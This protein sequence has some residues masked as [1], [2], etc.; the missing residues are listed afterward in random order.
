MIK[1]GSNNRTT[2]CGARLALAR[3]CLFALCLIWKACGFAVAQIPST[4]Q[5]KPPTV[6]I[7]T[8]Q[9]IRS[10][11]HILQKQGSVSF[12]DTPI[13]EVIYTLS[14]QWGVNIIAGS[15]VSGSVSGSFKDAP[16][17]EIL[18]SL[19]SVSGYGYRQNG[20]SLLVLR[21]DQIGP[22]NPNFRAETLLLPRDTSP[23]GMQDIVAALRVFSTKSGGQLQGIPANNTILAFDSPDKIEQMRQI[24]QRLTGM[25]S[26][27]NGQL[28][29]SGAL[30]MDAN[31]G[32]GFRTQ[33][34]D[35]VTLR[36][37]YISV[38]ELAKGVQLAIGNQGTFIPIE[39][40][41]AL[42]VIGQ[43]D[44]IRRVQQVLRQLDRPRAQVR[45]TAY[46]YDISLGEEEQSGVDWSSRIMGAGLD[47]NGIPRDVARSDSG[48]LTRVQPT[49]IVGNAVPLGSTTTTAATG[50]AAAAGGP[51]WVF[52]SLSNNFELNTAI[53]ALDETKGAKLLADPHVT[54]IDRQQASIN[55]ITKIPIQQLT[56]TQQGG[57]IGTTAFEE[58]GIKL[59]VTPRIASDRTIQMIVTPEVSTLTGYNNGNPIIDARRATTTVRVGNQHTL[60]IGGLRQKSAVETIRGVPGLM[61][62]KYLGRLFRSHNTTMKESEL[63]V[64][65]QPEIVDD[66]V[67]GLPRE[68]IALDNAKLELSRLPTSC[69]GPHTP[70]CRDRNCPYHHPRARTNRGHQ[71]DG[72]VYPPGHDV[73]ELRQE[74]GFQM[75]P[76][77]NGSSNPSPDTIHPAYSSSGS[78]SSAATSSTNPVGT[79]PNDLMIPRVETN[80]NPNAIHP[81]EVLQWDQP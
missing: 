57:S 14:Q 76:T 15:D 35:I 33:D 62:I 59:T 34:D 1:Q 70:D 28:A 52:R 43:P 74:S 10:M 21:Q 67:T 11:D 60:V 19:L 65:L 24:L 38:T 32:M 25:Q 61:N 63:I 42:M 2:I 71:D 17:R 4:T 72:F 13:A 22:S 5:L 8:S 54:V 58:A 75:Y 7:P 12:R 18:D 66:C 78:N 44:A 39:A 31:P 23:D 20:S 27:T 64:F 46:I 26:A 77:I 51:Q 80:T 40:E 68:E 50:A 9:S 6:G 69:L 48:L 30:G 41:E 81:A 53:Q 3:N 49:S 56:Q 47:A 79:T 73:E 36:P 55:I 45:I 37:Q 29:N 16:L